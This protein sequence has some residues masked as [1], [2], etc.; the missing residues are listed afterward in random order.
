[1]GVSLGLGGKLGGAGKKRNPYT[2]APIKTGFS[3]SADGNVTIDPSIRAIQEQGL[4]RNNN[5]YN[6]LGSS[7]QEILGNLR[8]TRS[9]YAG[10]Q[11]DYIRSQTNPLEQEL[12]TRQG[13]LERSIGM[14]GLA[15]SSFGEQALTGFAADKQRSIGD[16]R[17][18]AE[19]ESLQATTGIDAQMAQTLFQK[20]GQQMAITG[21]DNQMAQDRLRQELASLGVGQGQ[22]NAAIQAFE[23]WQN[24]ALSGAPE[25]QAGANFDISG[26]PNACFVAEVIYGVDSNITHTIRAY[27]REHADDDSLLGGFF[28]LYIKHG[29]SWANA[30]DGNRTLTSMAKIIWDKLYKMARK[31]EK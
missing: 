19:F 25:F 27:V 17:A 16:A 11:S 9:R 26:K 14:R 28:R 24:R 12:N 30:I 15:G 31:E 22:I 23:G 20:I 18:K 4:A 8:D 5:L 21:M 2:N 29:K 3:S 10:N 1:M 13:G 7:G 6:E